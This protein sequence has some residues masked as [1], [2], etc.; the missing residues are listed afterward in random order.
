[1]KIDSIFEAEKYKIMDLQQFHIGSH[2]SK[3]KTFNQTISRWLTHCYEN[4]LSEQSNYIRPCQI[5]TG[6]PKS[7]RRKKIDEK[8]RSLTNIIIRNSGVKCYVHSAYIIN[9]SHPLTGIDFAFQ[10]FRK[11][12]I[13]ASS[14]GCRGVVVHCGKQLKYP[15]QM[16]LDA[17]Y[18][19]LVNLSVFATNDC[20]ILLETPAGQGTEL[21]RRYDDFVQFYERFTEDERTKI[22]I[23]I[24]T[25]HVFAAGHCPLKYMRDWYSVFP[26]G[27][28]LVHFNDSKQVC[29]CC[30]DR[31]E[32]PGKGCIGIEKMTAICNWCQSIQIPMVYE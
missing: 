9:L 5:F 1:M 10:Y 2:I 23:C 25:C 21:L 30:K 31:H 6:S 20:P 18:Q 11:E 7:F 28:Q 13:M 19:N 29:G 8:D 32:Y 15:L 27:L 16:A 24:D 12:L 4:R 14:L 3:A 26:D 22:K 17:M